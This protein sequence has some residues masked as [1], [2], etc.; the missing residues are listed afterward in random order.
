[1]GITELRRLRI[2]EEEN[3]KP[4]QPVADLYLDKQMLQDILRIKTKTCSLSGI[5]PVTEDLL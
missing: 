5:W 1:V 4:K 3:R 2:L